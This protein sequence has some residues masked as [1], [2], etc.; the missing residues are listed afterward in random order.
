MIETVIN[1]RDHELWPKRKLRFEDAVAQTRVVLDAL[2][3]KGLIRRPAS[4]EEREGLVNEAAMTVAGQVDETLRDLAV[5]RLAE[6]RPE[7]GRGLV[8]EAI[9]ALLGRV[10]PAAVARKPTPAEREA[11]IESLAK[12]YGDRLAVQVLP[13][14]VTALDQ[15]RRAAADRPGRAPRS[16]RPARAAPV[17]CWSGPP[18][19]PATCSASP[20]RPCSPGSPTTSTPSH[21][22]PARGAD[23]VA[24]LGAV[25]PRRRRRQL[26]GP[27]GADE[28]GPRPQAG[29]A[30]RGA[31]RAARPSAPR[32]TSR[33]PTGSCSGRRRRPTWSRR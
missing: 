14:D 32:W 5:R 4:A 25:R 19:P 17:P 29:R 31:G 2:E 18:R 33:S 6:F 3:A 21:D 9:D 11:L 24:Q 20:G 15:R 12:T 26:G 28:A 23:Q 30:G 8:G 16:S 13:D 1:L 22:A 10:E 7:L 27:R